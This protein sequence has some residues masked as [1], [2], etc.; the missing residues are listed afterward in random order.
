MFSASLRLSRIKTL[1]FEYRF[2]PLLASSNG[3]CSFGD[4]YS[5]F[6][7]R[8]IS[9]GTPCA[10]LQSEPL[11]REPIYTRRLVGSTKM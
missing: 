7:Q 10:S 9:I 11:V 6:S 8:M 4:M 3:T 2:L 1:R 5:H